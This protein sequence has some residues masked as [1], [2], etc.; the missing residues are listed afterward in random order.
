M[1]FEYPPQIRCAVTPTRIER[2]VRFGES[3]PGVELWIKRDDQ[4]GFL[5]SGNKIR[6]L[7]FSFAR[8]LA[9]SVHGVVTCGGFDSNHCRATTFLARR[10]GL[11]SHLFLRS[12]D[13]KPVRDPQ[14][15]TLL[16][17]IAGAKIHWITPEQYAQRD[18]LLAEYVEEC[19]RGGKVLYAIPEGASNG[20]GAIGFIKAVEEL[21]S[22]LLA[23]NL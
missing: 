11:E 22:H 23:K 21:K 13:G 7:E 4:S 9:E 16:N 20:I 10:L 14:G 18:T 12:D 15:N 1:S 6:K 8:A 3:L 2:L 17:Q 19:A 5:L